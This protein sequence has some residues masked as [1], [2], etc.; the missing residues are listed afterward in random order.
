MRPGVAKNTLVSPELI[1]LY[2][3]H[4]YTLPPRQGGA[5]VGRYDS[6]SHI[7]NPSLLVDYLGAHLGRL[8]RWLRDWSLTTNIS[9]TTIV[10]LIKAARRIQKPRAMQFFGQP[11]QEV[12]TAMNLGVALGK[13]AY[14]VG[15]GEPRR[16]A[17]SSK[18]GC[19]G[20]LLNRTS[21]LSVRN[22][23]LLYEQHIRS[24]TD[25][26]RP[27]WRNVARSYARKLQILHSKW[28]HSA[29]DAPWY[30]IYRQIQEYLGIPVFANH[31]RVL[32]ESSE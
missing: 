17:D 28:L 19:A 1:S 21:G 29:T 27:I 4:T 8:D 13:S 31:I 6:R 12:E 3:R 23:V 26:A 11:I 24:M 7:R 25:H 10:L 14:L 5:V 16:K 20:P 22:G 18:I 9:K 15:A 2:E 32:I 30:V